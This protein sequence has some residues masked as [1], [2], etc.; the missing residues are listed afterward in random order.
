L[1]PNGHGASTINARPENR[2]V[3]RE[4]E[5]RCND[6][7][8]AVA[9]LEEDYRR[10]QR[11]DLASLTQAEYAVL[12]ALVSDVPTLWQAVETT[13]EDRKRLLR[14][15]VQEIVLCR[16]ARAKGAG[17]R[18]LIRIGWRGGAWTDLDV[19]RAS[20]GESARTAATTLERIQTLAQH[21]P[22]ER[23]AEQLTL[24]GRSTRQGLPWTA[25]RV[26]RLRGRHGIATACPLMPRQAQ[27][28]GDGLVPLVTAAAA[29]AW[30]LRRWSTGD[31]G[32]CCIWSKAGRAR[33]SGCASLSRSSPGSMAR[34]PVRGLANGP[35][36]KR[37]EPGA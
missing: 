26:Q 1:R 6:R 20:S 16:D 11:Q 10:E 25:L 21:L 37:S 27:T 33:R 3:A 13:I 36:A 28:R 32:A 14:C 19:R 2:L 23:I 7:L 30:C 15:L 17:G 34:R 4:L 22:D 12:R 31:A 8:R 18:T 35:R 9:E 5:T 29:W 24:E